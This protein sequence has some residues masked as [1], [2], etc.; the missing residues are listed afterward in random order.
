[1]TA[2]RRGFLAAL[3]AGLAPLGAEAAEPLLVPVQYGY[4]R[5]PRR[6]RRCRTV[7]EQVILRDRYGR[8]RRRWVTR[9]ICR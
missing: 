1:M 2:G 4:G 5:P 3:L 8:P 7:R 6:G 9:Q